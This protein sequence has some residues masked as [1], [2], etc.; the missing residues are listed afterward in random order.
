[1]TIIS[2]RQF[3]GGLSVAAGAAAVGRMTVFGHP[4][5]AAE[6]KRVLVVVNSNDIN[7]F[8]P[9]TNTDEPTTTLL[10]NLYDALVSTQEDPPRTVP[11]L[12][13]SWTTSPDGK[14]YIFRINP[15]AR[16]HNG[17]PVTA[18][19]VVYSFRRALRLK[20]GNS[21]MIA[22]ILGEQGIE[23]LDA[24]TVR[25][26]LDKPFG[27][28]LQVLP[29]IWVVNPK[30]VEAA[31]G[32]D[33][34]QTYLR[35]TV[36]GSGP[37]RLKH[38]EPGNLYELARVRDGWRR[39]DGDNLGVIY[40]IVRESGNQR[41]MIQ[42]G[43]A[44]VAST[45][46][47]D[48][49]IAL[50]GRKHIDLV[51]RPEFRMFMFRMNMKHGPLTDPALRK[52]VWHAVNYPAMIEVAVFGRPA[53]GPIPQGLFGY[54]SSL[55]M[56]RPDLALAKQY[57]ARSRYAN[58]SLTLRAAYIS[59]Y[60]QQRRWCLVLFDSL[61]QLGIHLDVRAVTW[62][63]MVASS[64]TP[65]S[66]PDFFSL[67]TSVNYAD[68]ADVSFNN[69]HSSRNGNWVNPTYANPAVDR[70][71]EAGRTEL[72]PER[73]LAI[74]RQFQRLVI[75]DTPDLFISADVRKIALR[76]NVTGFR[77]TPIRAGA[78]EFAQLSVKESHVV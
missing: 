41:L 17:E 8:D 19:A 47:N 9:H 5:S 54:D 7:N 78:L 18:D 61:K 1:M 60:E 11:Q 40:K 24:T 58:Q 72:D 3:I 52:A 55:P 38:A 64:R 43:D 16:F 66:C 21:Y 14:E 57:L 34:G 35:T 12:A 26:R 20:K 63:D 46:S 65:E 2:R 4:Q 74:Y 13:E 73:R 75:A 45:L 71:I 69:Y 76:S 15:A 77:Y 37:Y 31:A 56:L 32:N 10:K 44:H 50:R 67:F 39:A 22:G 53:R 48:D 23:A 27:P 6:G 25:L 42:R 51:I 33:D 29:W 30:Q 68:P 70:L 59:G 28:L 62:P 36:A 49:A